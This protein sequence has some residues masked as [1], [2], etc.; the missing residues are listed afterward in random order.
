M[1]P[2]PPSQAG[3]YITLPAGIMPAIHSF[4]IGHTS[5]AA[6]VDIVVVLQLM[7]PGR[8]PYAHCRH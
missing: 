4:A 3:V 5:H 1:E 8:Q 2:L 6:S 7:T